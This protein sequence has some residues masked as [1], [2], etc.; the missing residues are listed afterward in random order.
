MIYP[1]IEQ[2]ISDHS[3]IIK[4][5]GGSP[6][7]RDYKLLESSHL[8]PLQSFEENE[9]YPTIEEKFAALCYNLSQNHP[10]YDGNKRIAVH[11]LLVGLELNRVELTYNQQDLI[12]LG[13][14]IAKGECDKNCIMKWIY[15][16][17]KTF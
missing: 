4:Y 10:F 14:S 15:K 12:N 8:S 16:N 5:T 6:G 17:K 2:I 11:I 7:I 1:S 9:L 3:M 13:L